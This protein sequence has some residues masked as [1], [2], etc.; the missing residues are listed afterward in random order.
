MKARN[1]ALE[2]HNE[3]M[4]KTDDIDIHIA[5]GKKDEALALIKSLDHSSSH[6]VP[7]DEKSYAEYWTSKRKEYIVK[8]T[9]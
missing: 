3:L 4:K 5:Q 1:Q 7:N 8:A 9:A 2:L 6:I